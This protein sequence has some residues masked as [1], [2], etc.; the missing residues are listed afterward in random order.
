LWEA[1]VKKVMILSIAASLVL[2]LAS[3]ASANLTNPYTVDAAQAQFYAINN[4]GTGDSDGKVVSG[5]GASFNLASETPTGTDPVLPDPRP[6]AVWF[7]GATLLG[8]VGI[9]RRLCR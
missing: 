1:N 5:G 6:S 9:R 7:I 3:F 4:F 2:G 8:L